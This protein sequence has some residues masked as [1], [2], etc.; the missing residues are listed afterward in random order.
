MADKIT[1]NKHSLDIG[2]LE[3]GESYTRDDI[4]SIGSLPANPRLL[5]K[6]GEEL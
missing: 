3:V 2:L 6:T 4:R 1:W 5:K